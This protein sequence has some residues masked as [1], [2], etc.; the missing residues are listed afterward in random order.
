MIV[1]WVCWKLERRIFTFWV[2]HF[3]LRSDQ[4]ALDA[5][6]PDYSRCL[7]QEILRTLSQP[8]PLLRYYMDELLKFLKQTGLRIPIHSTNQLDSVTKIVHIWISISS[9]AYFSIRGLIIDIYLM[10]MHYIN[11]CKQSILVLE[12][13]Y[14]HH[15]QAAVHLWM[16]LGPLF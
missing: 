13:Y 8:I 6:V 9:V 3:C 2:T 7:S 16:S 12:S 15:H 5:L 4:S 1:G 14:H 10:Y 11:T